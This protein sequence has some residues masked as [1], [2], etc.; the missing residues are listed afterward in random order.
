MTE[1]FAF[2]CCAEKS[3]KRSFIELWGFFARHCS[4]GWIRY[5]TYTGIECEKPVFYRIIKTCIVLPY[6]WCIKFADC[7]SQNVSNLRN[8]N[9]ILRFKILDLIMQILNKMKIYFILYAYTKYYIRILDNPYTH[10]FYFSFF[11]IIYFE[12]NGTKTFKSYMYISF[13]INYIMEFS[14]QYC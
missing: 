13:C 14:F 12:F 1:N 2:Q 10:V 8:C 4:R 9:W 3:E 11:W 6:E 5:F 7:V